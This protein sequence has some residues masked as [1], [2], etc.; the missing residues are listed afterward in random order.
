MSIT[1]SII[2]NIKTI[3]FKNT[4]GSSVRHSVRER[5]RELQIHIIVSLPLERQNSLVTISLKYV[6]LDRILPII[7][8]QSRKT[9]GF[10]SWQWGNT[11]GE[12]RGSRPASLAKSGE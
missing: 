10:H 8:E 2:S 12:G 1:S 5:A 9:R 6:H 3:N 4:T 7:T 11:K